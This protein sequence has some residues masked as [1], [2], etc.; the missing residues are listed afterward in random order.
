MGKIRDLYLLQDCMC[1]I[2]NF[3]L[4]IF[5]KIIV[6]ELWYREVDKVLT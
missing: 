3:D 1:Y 4:F 5:M 2:Y 6:S